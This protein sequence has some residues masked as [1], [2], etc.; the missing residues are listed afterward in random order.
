M[1][2]DLQDRAGFDHRPL[3]QE[4]AQQRSALAL[5][6]SMALAISTAVAATVVSIGIARAE[7]LGSV[8]NGTNRPVA[9][10]VLIGVVLA[11]MGGLTAMVTRHELRNPPAGPGDIP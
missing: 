11:G 7:I 3:H 4:T 6:A 10:A 9:V 5:I 1:S 8:A 2:S